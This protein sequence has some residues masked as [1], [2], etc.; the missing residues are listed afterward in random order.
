[1][2]KCCI[3]A[4]QAW[5]SCRTV[6][7][8]FVVVK[9]VFL[10]VLQFSWLIVNEEMLCSYLSLRLRHVICLSSHHVTSWFS[11]EASPL[12]GHLAELRLRVNFSC[13]SI[14]FVFIP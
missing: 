14:I 9:W 5:V 13:Y 6:H 3:Y 11:D 4:G 1:V 12:T 8:E 2:I 10:Q 7:T